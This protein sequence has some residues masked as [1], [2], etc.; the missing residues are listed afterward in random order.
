MTSV[1]MKPADSSFESGSPQV[2]GVYKFLTQLGLG[3][4]EMQV[5]GLAEHFDSTRFNLTFG[6]IQGGGSIEREYRI[7]GWSISDY[8]ITRFASIRTGRQILRLSRELRVRKPQIL[9]SYNFYANVFSI[10]AARMA[11]VPC[12]VAS[13]RDMGVYLT[14]MQLRV[15]RWVCEMADRIV[16]NADAIRDWLV[17]EGYSANKISVIRNGVRLPAIDNK[18][19]RARIR[20][21]LGIPSNAKVVMM[22]SRL[23]PKKGVEYLLDSIPGV[24][25]R[26]PDA[27]FVVVGDAVL[28]SAEREKEYFNGLAE[29]TRELGV[30][31][32]VILTGLRRDVADLLTAAD[33]SV[34]PS[35]SEGLPNSVIE[36]MSAG[37]PVV[38]SR[39]GGIPELVQQG[40]TGL[41]VPPG[42]AKA[43]CEAM[44]TLLSNPFLA[45]RIGEAARVRIRNEFSFEKMFLETSALYQDVLNQKDRVLRRWVKGES[46]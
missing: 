37:L 45:R 30:A 28:E 34:L 43:L 42:D 44:I 1:T 17:E 46:S 8:P 20:T 14:P 16:V 21:E 15:Q 39:V 5:L 3:G 10:P 41:L 38:A 25:A 35:F 18:P 9:H 40:R 2:L 23:N 31:D 29:R 36:A 13:I 4:T 33:L 7:R 19:V 22:V 26:I 27:W 11:G 24:L 12:I 6:C 32:R